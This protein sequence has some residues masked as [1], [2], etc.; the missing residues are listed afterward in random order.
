MIDH[1]SQQ[2]RW[3]GKSSEQRSIESYNKIPEFPNCHKLEEPEDNQQTALLLSGSQNLSS[4]DIFQ[5]LSV[6]VCIPTQL[7]YSTMHLTF[8]ESFNLKYRP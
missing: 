4:P 3:Q 8:Q 2:D 6:D 5:L 1:A 7:N